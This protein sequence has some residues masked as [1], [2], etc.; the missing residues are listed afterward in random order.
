[1]PADLLIQ[2]YNAT[3]ALCHHL[4]AAG[5]MLYHCSPTSLYEYNAYGKYF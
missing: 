1:M 4:Q 5:K 3:A 2:N